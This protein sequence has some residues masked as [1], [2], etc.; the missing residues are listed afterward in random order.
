MCVCVAEPLSGLYLGYQMLHQNF[1]YSVVMSMYKL[2]CTL[3]YNNEVCS[4]Q[5]AKH[6]IFEWHLRSMAHSFITRCVEH[7]S[8][9]GLYIS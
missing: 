2:F 7:N 9:T 5:A 8:N 3:S 1:Y 4:T 6:E